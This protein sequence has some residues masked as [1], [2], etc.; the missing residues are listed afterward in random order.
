MRESSKSRTLAVDTSVIFRRNKTRLTLEKHFTKLYQQ[1]KITM[2]GPEGS[3]QA[4]GGRRGFGGGSPMLR[5]FY[6]LF[7]L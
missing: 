1:V 4:A 5:Q 3:A 7:F 6:R 2:W